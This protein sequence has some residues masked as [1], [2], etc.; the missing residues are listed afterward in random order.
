MERE[1]KKSW[2]LFGKH[3][4]TNDGY[5][6]IEWRLASENVF[7]RSVPLILEIFLKNFFLNSFAVFK[8]L[9]GKEIAIICSPANRDHGRSRTLS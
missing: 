2:N 7:F 5:K 9:E 6:S 3:G 8:G 4:L 1:E